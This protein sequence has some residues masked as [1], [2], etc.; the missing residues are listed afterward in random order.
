MSLYPNSGISEEITDLEIQGSATQDGSIELKSR[1]T[2]E[3]H[4]FAP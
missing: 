1:E 4:P 2:V 3:A